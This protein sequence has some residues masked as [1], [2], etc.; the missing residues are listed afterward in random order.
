MKTYTRPAYKPRRYYNGDKT[1]LGDR[2]ATCRVG[3][4]LL[5]AYADDGWTG[6]VENLL[7]KERFYVT[8]DE[9]DLIERIS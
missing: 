3:T 6:H 4:C 2:I 8:L 1:K 9:C 7:T 5:L